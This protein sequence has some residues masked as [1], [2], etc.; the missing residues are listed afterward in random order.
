MFTLILL[1]SSGTTSLDAES[2]SSILY[3]YVKNP[4]GSYG[5]D[6]SKPVPYYNGSDEYIEIPNTYS[7]KKEQFK[8]TWIATIFNIHFPQTSDF[9]TIKQEYLTRLD[10]I[11]SM[12]MNAVIFQVRPVL[13]A[14]F[15]QSDIN[16]TSAHFTGKQGLDAGFDP[17]PWMIDETHNRGLEF[18]AWFNPYRV[19]NTAFSSIVKDLSESE[20]QELSIK[21]KIEILNDIGYLADNNFA[22]LNPDYVLEFQGKFFLNP[23]EPKVIGHVVDT[24]KEFMTKYDTDAI[25]FDDYFYPYRS[26][27]AIFGTNGEDLETYEKYGQDYDDIESWR[28]ANVTAL[29]DAVKAAIDQH[30]ASNKTAVQFGV[31]P[32]GI[33]EHKANDD[34]GS[35]TP[36]SSS[37][38][39]S[40][41]IFADTYSWIKDNKLD[42]VAPQIYWSFASAAAPYGELARWWNNVAEGTDVDVYVGHANYKTIGNASWDSDWMNPEEINN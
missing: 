36:A 5:Y 41:S 20:I 37:Q 22:V 24:L 10:T 16:P 35:N 17:M 19:T 9:E 23:G 26:G 34:R 21:D 32:F 1:V 29:I 12:N 42:Y 11:E 40:T 4:D 27:D 31:S 8:S 25:H 2:E 7:Q 39:Y 14:A 13:D 6:T 30:N 28:R 38:S 33:W 15:Y 18:H 3:K